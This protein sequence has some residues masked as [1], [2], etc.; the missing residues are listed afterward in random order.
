MHFQRSITGPKLVVPFYVGLYFPCN[1]P[2]QHVRNYH[3]W[4]P[5]II[6]PKYGNVV[7]REK[8]IVNRLQKATK[9]SKFS[10]TAQEFDIVLNSREQENNP[11]V[12]P[13]LSHHFNMY[14]IWAY[15]RQ[16]KMFQWT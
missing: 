3:A 2:L 9:R 12:N 5:S 16:L 6:F 11:K 14:S 15:V 13:N 10:R 4:L 7:E 1:I 8:T